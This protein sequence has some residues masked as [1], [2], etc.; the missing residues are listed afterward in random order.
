M[1]FQNIT[2]FVF[3]NES[4]MIMKRKKIFIFYFFHFFF[5]LTHFYSDFWSTATHRTVY[6]SGR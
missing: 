6:H 2:D 1:P 5:Q 4:I 3:L